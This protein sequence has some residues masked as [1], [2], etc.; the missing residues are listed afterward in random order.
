LLVTDNPLPHAAKNQHIDTQLNRRANFTIVCLHLCTVFLVI[1]S[2]FL[3]A[4]DSSMSMS[5]KPHAAVDNEFNA[6]SD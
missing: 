6:N 3:Y 5:A 4:F 1:S 2:S